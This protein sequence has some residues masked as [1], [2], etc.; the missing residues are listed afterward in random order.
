[1]L[2]S[3]R[4]SPVD[5]RPGGRSMRRP[6]QHRRSRRRAH[7]RQR[8]PESRSPPA[9]A[10]TTPSA[11]T[12]A[13]DRRSPPA[14]RVEL[15]ARLVRAPAAPRGSHAI[16]VRRAPPTLCWVGDDP[17]TAASTTA[18]GGSTTSPPSESSLRRFL[19]GL[20]GRRPGRRRGRAPPASAP[21]RSR[22]RP[23]PA[24]IDLAIRMV[25]LTTLEGAGH[26]RQGARA[27]PPRRCAPTRPTRPARRRRPSASTPTWSRPPRQTLGDSG[28]QRR[29]GRHRVP[30]RPRRARHQARRH[31]RR[32]RGRRRRDRHGDR[33]RRVPVRPLPAGLRRDRRGQGGLRGRRRPPQ[34][35][36]RDR[37]AADLRQRPPGVA[38]WRCWPAADFIKTSTGKVQPGRDAAGHAGHAR[39]G[40]RLPRGRPAR[41][42]A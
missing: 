8:R 13:E 24:R 41:W 6:D 33:P 36:L 34:G 29:R 3:T 39:G 17:T 2:R 4:A 22:P 40:P 27:V 11:T 28:V 26:P 20:P 23:R 16:A 35:D 42:S 12:S 10:S 7:D 19:H 30:Q 21:A 5:A 31:P 1:M 25:D 32:R 9:T 15:L 37:R 14:G 38:G 18:P